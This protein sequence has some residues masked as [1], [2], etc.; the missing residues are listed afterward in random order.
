MLLLE[1]I[2][3]IEHYGLL[4]NKLPDGSY[5]PVNITHSWNAP[6]RISN[7]FLFKLQRHSDHHAFAHKPYQVL[8]SYDESPL[9]PQGYLMMII[10]AWYPSLYFEI[11]N[12]TLIRYKN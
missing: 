9:L 8:K 6:H 11:M 4:R 12:E 10:L 2:N 5:E 3:Y 7:Y 1:T